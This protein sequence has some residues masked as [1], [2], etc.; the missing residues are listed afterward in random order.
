MWA[1]GHKCNQICT[2]YGREKNFHTLKYAHELGSESVSE[3]ASER[4]SERSGAPDQNE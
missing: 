2:Q 1:F 4:T 3:R